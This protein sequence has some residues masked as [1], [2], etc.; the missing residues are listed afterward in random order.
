[1][2][3]HQI[4]SRRSTGRSALRSK[5]HRT[6]AGPPGVDLRDDQR[7]VRF[8]GRR[9]W[10]IERPT[11][12]VLIFL[13]V[14]AEILLQPHLPDRLELCLEPV[15]VRFLT[16]DHPLQHPASRE[17]GH[18]RAVRDGRSERGDLVLLKLERELEMLG[19]VLANLDTS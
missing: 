4:S 19:H 1:M 17:V 7:N 15:N 13:D 3:A 18:L 2:V 6:A 12:K 5:W 9:F 11:V 14:L 8:P 10:A 16:A